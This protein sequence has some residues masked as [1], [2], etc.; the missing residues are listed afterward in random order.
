SRGDQPLERPFDRLRWIGP[1]V[2]G[3]LADPG[4]ELGDRLLRE[5]RAAERHLWF[6]R[7]SQLMNEQA[8][9]WLAC[10]DRLAGESASH[11]SIEPVEAKLPRRL[12]SRV[13]IDAVLDDHRRQI[14]QEAD[15]VIATAGR[16]AGACGVGARGC[17]AAA[18]A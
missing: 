9:G 1:V 15:S 4:F 14:A 6:V 13:A 18:L 7:A 2:R 11:Q 12:S 16:C 17:A 8:I 5:R 3:A 10:D